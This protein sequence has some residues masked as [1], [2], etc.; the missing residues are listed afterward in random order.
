VV[1]I[2]PF[3]SSR[4]GLENALL[5][6]EP[7]LAGREGEVHRRERLGGLLNHY[8]RKAARKSLRPLTWIMVSNG[9]KLAT[10]QSGLLVDYR[11]WN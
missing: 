10:L 7:E 6:P 4:C 1:I 2:S 8:Y 3:S 11:A 9:P 5:C